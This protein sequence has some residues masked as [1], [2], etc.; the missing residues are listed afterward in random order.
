MK[1][2]S[3]VGLHGFGLSTSGQSRPSGKLPS[4]HENFKSCWS[5]WIWAQLLFLFSLLGYPGYEKARVCVDG[6]KLITFIPFYL[7]RLTQGPR[8]G[9]QVNKCKKSS[10][11]SKRA[12]L[13]EHCF[14]V[15]K[16]TNVPYI[17]NKVVLKCDLL[18]PGGQIVHRGKILVR[19]KVTFLA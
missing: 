2:S 8:Q 15:L 4:F 7:T 13:E 3:L 14:K 5:T 18:Q 16:K 6:H 19:Q 12:E 1:T 9:F 10:R 17:S 11:I